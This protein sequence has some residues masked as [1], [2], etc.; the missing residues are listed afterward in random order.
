MYN[1]KYLREKIVRN[2][3]NYLLV[4]QNINN[5]MDRERYLS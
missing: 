2:S 5:T 1:C 3:D 4:L